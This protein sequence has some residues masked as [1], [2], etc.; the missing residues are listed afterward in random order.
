MIATYPTQVPVRTIRLYG[1]LGARFGRSHRLAVSSVAEAVRALCAMLPGFEQFMLEAKE[2]HKLVFTVF[3]GR[4][5]LVEDEL[6]HPVDDDIRIAPLICGSK[7]GGIF[8]AILG[9]VMVVVG[10]VALYFGQPWG[11]NLIY[12]GAAMLVGG[13]A[14]MLAP[15]PKDPKAEDDADKKASYAF[16]GPV[17]TQAQ[18]NPV[19]VFFGGPMK[20]GSAVISASI[21]AKDQA[22]VPVNG[23]SNSGGGGGAGWSSLIEA[24]RAAANP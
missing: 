8:N 19:P 7:Q 6:K 18:G 24:V 17:N 4:R 2:K 22:Y 9:A 11:L 21:E 14:Q 16:N 20:I 5:N 15:Q 3:V 1:K 10:V 13:I 23:P 12:A